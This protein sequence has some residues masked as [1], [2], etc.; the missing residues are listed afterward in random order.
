MK[1]RREELD[2]I[3]RYVASSSKHP[4]FLLIPLE[5]RDYQVNFKIMRQYI[6]KLA[7]V[8]P[9]RFIVFVGSRNRLLGYTTIEKFRATFP[10]FGIEI[11]LEDLIN[12]RVKDAELPPIFNIFYDTESIDK[13]LERLV[14][15]QWNPN[16]GQNSDNNKTVLPTDLTK[17]N[18][19][20]LKTKV[21]ASP[22]KVYWL[23]MEYNLD[24]IP[25]VD[26][27]GKFIGIVTKERITQAVINQL[28]EKSQKLD[29]KE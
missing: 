17:L 19:S 3:I 21:S 11:F 13:Y 14:Y 8:A 16:R 22:S 4:I 1:G 26:S 18:A 6:Y 15:S 20:D 27:G 25:V 2:S 28:L 29:I 9:I 12:Q 5:E 10:R 24:G 7:E 23:L